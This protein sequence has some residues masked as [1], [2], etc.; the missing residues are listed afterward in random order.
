MLYSTIEIKPK[1]FEEGWHICNYDIPDDREDDAE[2]LSA[3]GFYHYSREI[4]ASK[5]FE[6]LRKYM[7]HKHQDQIDAYLESIKSLE[8]LVNPYEKS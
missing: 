7:I 2:C 3:L 6:K 5:A 8:E 1:A 4:G